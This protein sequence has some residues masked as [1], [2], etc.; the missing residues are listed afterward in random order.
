MTDEKRR[1]GEGGQFDGVCHICG[2]TE[3]AKASRKGKGGVAK[4][5]HGYKGGYNHPSSSYKEGGKFLNVCNW[6]T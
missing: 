5:E 1:G 4:N 6:Q 3:Q 2:E